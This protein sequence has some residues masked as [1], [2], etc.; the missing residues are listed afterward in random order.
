VRTYKLVLRSRVLL[1]SL[2]EVLLVLVF[3]GLLRAGVLLL[4]LGRCC[5]GSSHLGSRRSREFSHLDDQL[6]SKIQS[7]EWVG[8]GKVESRGPGERD[9]I[10]RS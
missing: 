8:R 9:G 7:V 5:V 10:V 2:G 6:E 1:L 4:V 3:V